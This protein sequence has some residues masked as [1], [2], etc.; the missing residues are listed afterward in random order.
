[1]EHRDGAREVGGEDE[2]RLERGDEN[3]LAVGVVPGDLRSEL[4]DARGDLGRGEVDL[5]DPVVRR[6]MP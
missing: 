2:A 3:R 4:A 5:S 6:A 1:V